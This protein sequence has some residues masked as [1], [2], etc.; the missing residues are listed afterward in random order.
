MVSLRPPWAIAY[1]KIALPSATN[2]DACSLSSKTPSMHVGYVKEN[3]AYK[4]SKPG[5]NVV[6]TDRT[7][8][9]VISR[10]TGSDVTTNKTDVEAETNDQAAHPARLKEAA[11]LNEE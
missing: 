11:G 3:N 6:S 7:N 4:E 1:P 9:V 5:K 10:H 8:D 2:F